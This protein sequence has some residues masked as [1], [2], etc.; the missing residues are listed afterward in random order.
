MKTVS[1]RLAVLAIAALSSAY[2][3]AD[4]QVEITLESVS[5]CWQGDG[6]PEFA[7]SWTINQSAQG[8]FIKDI[9][10]RDGSND[11]ETGAWTLKGKLVTAITQSVEGESVDT[12]DPQY[13][14]FFEIRSLTAKSMTFFDLKEGVSFTGARVECSST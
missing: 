4:P 11:R 9:H 8:T 5:G 3:A 1:L 12:K 13:T 6:S 14:D 7:G 10:F 2:A